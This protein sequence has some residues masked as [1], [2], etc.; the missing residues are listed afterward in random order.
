[1][2]HIWSAIR[3]KEDDVRFEIG[4]KNVRCN[5]CGYQFLTPLPPNREITIVC[6]NCASQAVYWIEWYVNEIEEEDEVAVS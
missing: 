5:Q 1:M 3:S 4:E 2:S 6:P